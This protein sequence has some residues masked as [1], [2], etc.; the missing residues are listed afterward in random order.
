MLRLCHCSDLEAGQEGAAWVETL[1]GSL[2][3]P[4][5]KPERE[6][7]REKERGCDVYPAQARW[8]V[9]H[10]CLIRPGDPG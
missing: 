10:I 3:S 8:I 9:I 7:E 5:R 2:K 1:F 6:R 4:L